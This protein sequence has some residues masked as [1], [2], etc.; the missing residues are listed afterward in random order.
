MSEPLSSRCVANECR[1]VWHPTRLVR[2]AARPASVTA[3]P[4]LHDLELRE[5]KRPRGVREHHPPVLLPLATPHGD[6]WPLSAPAV[7]LNVM[8]PP[9]IRSTRPYA[10]VP[11]RNASSSVTPSGVNSTATD[12]GATSCATASVTELKQRTVR[13]D[14]REPGDAGVSV[15]VKCYG[16]SQRSLAC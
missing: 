16:H 5:Q 14:D 4:S 13:Q 1:K 10:R 11:S 12:C 6:L 15:D 7:V 3:R 9:S 2:P 8:M